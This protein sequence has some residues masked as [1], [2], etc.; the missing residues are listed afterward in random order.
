LEQLVEQRTSELSETNQA[1]ET[2]KE[3]LRFL[4]ERL[5]NAKEEE[6]TRIARELHDELGQLLTSIKIELT[7]L[8]KHLI[9]NRGSTGD[10]AHRCRSL[11]DMTSS[12]IKGVQEITKAL[13]PPMLDD[14]GLAAALKSMVTDFE[15]R[16]G[17]ACTVQ[18]NI[19]DERYE[20]AFST[21]VYRIVQE[22][23]TNVARHAEADAVSLTIDEERGALRLSIGD[24][25]KGIKE[26]DISDFHSFGILGMVERARS[27]GGEL[28]VDRAAETGTAVQ[29]TVPV[30]R[31]VNENTYR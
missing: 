16:T 6:S 24:N 30:R 10:V 13:R 15:R 27:F 3:Q 23:L 26:G 21:A 22:S 12:A 25:G 4:G 17:I 20:P 14:I 5:A 28:T 8:D 29:L 31:V 1:L 11:L 9:K 18:N 7:L 19:G 2:S